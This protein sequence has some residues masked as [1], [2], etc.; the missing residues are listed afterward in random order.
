MLLVSNFLH[1]FFYLNK[2]DDSSIF[3]IFFPEL[4]CADDGSETA[5]LDAPISLPQ[6]P[7]NIIESEKLSFTKVY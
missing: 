1:D 6:S 7:Y 2:C 4:L 5:L 3:F